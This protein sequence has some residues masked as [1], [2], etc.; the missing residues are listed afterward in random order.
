MNTT[1]C[2]T[3]CVAADARRRRVVHR[4]GILLLAVVSAGAMANGSSYPDYR[5]IDLGPKAVATGSWGTSVQLNNRGEVIAQ[6]STGVPDPFNPICLNDC[7]V[8]TGVVGQTNGVVRDLGSLPGANNSAPVWISETGLIAGS[9]QNGLID[10]DTAF[11]EFRAVLWNQDRS[12]VDLGTLGGNASFAL[13]VN[14]RGQVVGVALNAIAED[15]DLA[16]GI[17]T[18]PAATQARAFLWQKGLMQDLG[19]LG[20]NDATA[21]AVN[22]RGQIVGFSYTSTTPNDDGG[23]TIH[24]FLYENG[25]MRDL[26]S[27]GGT[28]AIPGSLGLGGGTRVL[29]ESGQVIGT[30]SLPGTNLQHAFLWSN[31][32]MIDL[33]TLGG[34]T[35]DAVAINNKGQVVG[36]ARVTDTPFV[37]HA[38]LWEDGQMIDLGAP[39]PCTRSTA[40][41][42]NSANQI[43]GS[44]GGC[45]D[46]S[47][48]A[49]YVEKGNPMVDLNTL[50]VPPSNIHLDEA[51]NINDRGE[52]FGSGYAPDGS[53][54]AV[55]LVPLP[56]R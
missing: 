23:F 53:T 51:W 11:P 52:I 41:S 34:T 54:R 42:I 30:S 55:L 9:S 49:F 29:N 12:I 47:N 17:A 19:T 8:W 2:S 24:P 36:R 25:T 28:T 50:I 27:L 33:G 1:D 21:V 37:R 15:P 45:A 10:P 44:L 26:G 48:S 14:S 5:M 22:E 7:F 38:F 39:A 16:S 3:P 46:N 35:S 56:R 20:G 40:N 31:G 6:R 18:F 13:A 32:K 4:F 43:V